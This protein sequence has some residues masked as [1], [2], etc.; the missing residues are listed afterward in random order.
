MR[1]STAIDILRSV[2]EDES[3]LDGMANQLK[4]KWVEQEIEIT[5]NHE[6]ALE[7]Q[8]IILEEKKQAE[9]KLVEENER[10]EAEKALSRQNMY[11]Y[12][13][14]STKIEHFC[15]GHEK[16][17]CNVINYSRNMV[18]RTLLLWTKTETLF[19]KKIR[20]FNP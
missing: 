11:Q 4:E 2:V 5:K 15:L 13:C 7:N 19:S 3:H 20:Y 1:C 14:I 10:K 6:Q 8:K 16:N 18:R 17:Y 12:L 9:L